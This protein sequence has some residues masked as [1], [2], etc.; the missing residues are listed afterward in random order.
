[1]AT[2]EATVTRIV[3]EAGS[4]VYKS[5]NKR[6]RIDYDRREGNNW[7]STVESIELIKGRLFLDFY[8]QYENTDTN[9][10]E[11]FDKFFDRRNSYR[12]EIR[13]LDRYGNG[14][15]YYFNYDQSDKAQVMKSILLEYVYGKYNEKLKEDI[16]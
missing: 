4:T 6:L 3:K 2:T 15:T 12:G 9:T 16:V 5:R 11:E 14:R 10:S 13:R 8:V 7:N 1:M